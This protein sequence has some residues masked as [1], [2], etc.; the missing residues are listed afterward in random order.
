[1]PLTALIPEDHE[2]ITINQGSI[3]DCYLLATLDCVA[4]VGTEGRERLKSLFTQ[5]KEGVTVRIPRSQI[6][7]NLKLKMLEKRYKY[8]YGFI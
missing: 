6:S 3:G 8:S 7:D 2:K 4:N 1:M 5:T